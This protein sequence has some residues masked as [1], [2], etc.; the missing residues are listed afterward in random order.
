MVFRRSLSSATGWVN[1]A[2]SLP[3][4]AAG[5]A[6]RLVILAYRLGAIAASAL[7]AV[8]ERADPFPIFCQLHLDGSRAICE[9]SQVDRGAIIIAVL[10]AVGA[11]TLGASRRR[12][13]KQPPTLGQD[14][15]RNPEAPESHV[16]LKGDV[17]KVDR[18]LLL[19]SGMNRVL[20]IDYLYDEV[21]LR[22]I[23]L[24]AAHGT[25]PTIDI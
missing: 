9:H 18:G 16:R 14:Y 8:G 15:R 23:T 5:P 22:R 19:A 4:K 7:K 20:D 21:Y 3:I 13:R 12:R 17:V 11:V 6:G 10:A 25:D 2:S 1:S 24:R